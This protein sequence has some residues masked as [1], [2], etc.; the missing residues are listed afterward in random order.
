MKEKDIYFFREGNHTKLY[1][2]L[3]SH[4]IEHEGENGTL[5]SVWAPDAAEVSVIGDF[6]YWSA[7]SHPLSVRWDNSGVWEGFVPGVG[8]GDLYKYAIKTRKGEKLEKGDPFA[9]WWETPPRSASCVWDLDGFG[10]ADDEWM[11]E[12][13]AKNATT[14]PQSIYEVH[15]GSWRHVAEDSNRSLS[16]H[17]LATALTEYVTE[18]GFTHVEF[19]PVMEH[20]FYGSWGYQ[21]LGYFAP[22]SRFGTPH[23]FMELVDSL[24]NAGIGIILDWVPSHF[25]SDGYGLSNFD[26]TCLYEHEDPRKGYHP[27]WKSSIFNYGR[28][29]VRSFLLSSARF[30]LERYHADGLRVDAVA[31]MLYLDYSRKNGEW[32]PNQYGG[33]ENIEAIDF[34]RKMNEI[35]YIDFKGMQTTAEESTSWPMVSRPG[36]VG[37]LGFGYKWNMGWMS[38]TL[39]YFSQDPIYRKFYQNRL[40]FGMWYAY[41][42]NFTLPLSHDE[43]VYGKGSLYN[44]MPGNAWQKSANLKLLLGWQIGHPGKKLLFMGGEFGQ[45]WE[46]N[47][48]SC[49]SWGDLEYGFHGGIHAWTKAILHYYKNC[50]ALWEGDYNGWGF[51]WVDCGDADASVLSFIRRAANGSVI[52]CV[53]NFTPV[54]RVGYKIGVPSNGFWMES[55]NSDSEIFGGGNWGNFGGL[56]AIPYKIHGREWALDLTLPALSF[57]IFEHGL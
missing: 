13:E 43:V 38:D 10:W 52:L 18:M 46:W 45:E 27:D 8:H 50:P 12:R 31:S 23:E 41:S 55:L 26:G 15:L 48:D 54:P 6:N 40:T 9:F 2:V 28:N 51:E 5:F 4:V 21:T 49:L 32:I 35:L 42:E 57:L 29:E 36:Y 19:L 7:W 22:S 1:D 47:H 11:L 30:W 20:P 53:G 39:S 44:K 33:K 37:G 24:H 16:Y 56:N 17:E 14:A 3:G 25:P 34:L